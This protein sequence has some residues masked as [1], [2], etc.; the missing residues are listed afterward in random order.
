MLDHFLY[1]GDK[2]DGSEDITKWKLA[3]TQ[4]SKFPN[5]YVKLSG[6]IMDSG[7][8]WKEE[9]FIPYIEHVVKEFGYDRLVYCGNNPVALIAGILPEQ[10]IAV[11]MK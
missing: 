3:N 4:L 5:T 8:N 6:L 11:L 1:I 2:L 9:N 7:K 10:W